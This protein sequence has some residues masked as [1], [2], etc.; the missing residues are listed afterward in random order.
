MTV[1]FIGAGPGDPE[2]ITVKGSRLI[3]EADLVLYA[4]SL[5]PP[6]VVAH[7]KPGARVIDSAP[8][9][10][11]ETHALLVETARAGG[12][13]VRVH[14]G[15]PSLYGA[16][17]EQMRLLDAEG[18]GYEV[19]PGVT[20]AFAAAATAGLSLTVPERSQTVILTRTPGRTPMPEG[21]RLRDLAR[22]RC[23]LAI[24]LSAADPDPMVAELRAGGLSAATPV[25]AAYRVGWPDEATYPT[26]LGGLCATV[27]EHGLTRQTLFL[28]LPG[29]DGAAHFSKLYAPDF[30]HGFREV[31]TDAGNKE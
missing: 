19:V 26:T 2:L 4:G 17:R 11:D 8:L 5:V 14:T 1:Y 16:M 23:A 13:A 25:L 3:G 7:A 27:R 15:D 29:E 30:A 22:H 31:A 21:E 24:Y 12:M 18:I 6:A 20:A 28:V 9:N 10:L